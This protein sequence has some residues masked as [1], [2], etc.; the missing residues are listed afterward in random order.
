MEVFC[1]NVMYKGGNIHPR[2]RSDE[3][4]REENFTVG[5]ERGGVA[6]FFYGRK[7]RYSYASIKKNLSVISS[8][9]LY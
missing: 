3:T 9:R 1:T 7:D 8:E 4:R 6:S 5:K 2:K